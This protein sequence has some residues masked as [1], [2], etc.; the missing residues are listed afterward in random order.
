MIPT[1]VMLTSALTVPASAASN[2]Y[3]FEA[4]I[5]SLKTIYENLDLDSYGQIEGR[6]L[7]RNT[8]GIAR[9]FW[10]VDSAGNYPHYN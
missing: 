5:Y 1:V 10:S 3:Q 6:R 2:P 7:N 8:S 9:G 4:R